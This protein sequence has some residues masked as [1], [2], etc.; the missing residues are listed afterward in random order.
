VKKYQ[1]SPILKNIASVFTS[2]GYSCFLVGGAVRN[3]VLKK[4]PVDYD[5]ATDAH[6]DE[7]MSIF[8]KVIPTGIQHGTVTV[9]FK[10]KTFEVTTFR[11]EGDYSDARHPDSI[12]FTPSIFDDL[13]RRDFTI[14]AMAI[15]LQSGVFYDPHG[16]MPDLQK[17]IIRAIGDPLE[18]FEEDGLRPLRAVRF[19]S[20][21]EFTIEDNTYA[22]IRKTL[23]QLESVSIERVRNEIE[24]IL[25][26]SHP[27]IGLEHMHTTGILSLFIP[28]LSACAGIPQ[29]GKENF[30]LLMHSILSCEGAPSDRL[31]IRLA[32]LLHDIGKVKTIKTE[33]DGT[34]SFHGHEKVSADLSDSILQRM[35][36]P[37]TIRKKV[38]HLI[39][40]HMFLYEETWGDSAVRRFISRVG[41]DNITDLFTL[42]RADI[43]GTSTQLQNLPNLE[44]FKNH[45]EHVLCEDNALTIKDLAVDGNILHEKA[46]IPKNRH[47]GT[48]LNFLLESVL[49]DPLLNTEDTLI[50][51]A[52]NFYMRRIN[53]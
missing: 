33:P 10:G 27:S 19:A 32:A 36:F 28:E 3:I 49:D 1:L 9:L 45:I 46:G 47:M 7:V 22:S 25:E 15:D 30:D 35:K 13:K 23:P 16:G 37:N 44:A 50:T 4:K 29:K 21:L 53:V 51:L 8:R 2:N 31:D 52:K 12:R 17:K 38:L 14:N 42:R 26:S 43:F 40:H 48:V 6:P 11:I 18:R 5:L 34:V 24:K 41:K 20:Q 39:R